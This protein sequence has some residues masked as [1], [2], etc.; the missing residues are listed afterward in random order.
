MQ[1][2]HGLQYLEGGCLVDAAIISNVIGLLAGLTLCR[3]PSK[4]CNGIELI[5]SSFKEKIDREQ[6]S[7]KTKF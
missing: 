3:S 5:V 6:C 7:G 2:R 4:V 1:F